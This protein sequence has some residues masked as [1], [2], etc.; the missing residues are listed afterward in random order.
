MS[1]PKTFPSIDIRL[2]WDENR[3]DLKKVQFQI[4]LIFHII[5]STAFKL[6]IYRM[7]A[8]CKDN[9][10]ILQKQL[11]V[12]FHSH[13][14]WERNCR[15]VLFDHPEI[16]DHIS[17]LFDHPAIFDQNLE[18]FDQISVLFDQPEIF[19]H[20]PEIFDHRFKIFDKISKSI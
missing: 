5:G 1:T 15:S 14:I 13:A 3:K 2:W 20:I 18:L 11:P 6:S 7:A 8:L 4:N 19:D 10:R 17:V 12:L 16:F 9:I